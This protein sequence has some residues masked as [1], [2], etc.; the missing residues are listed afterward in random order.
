MFVSDWMTTKVFSVSANDNVA[1][2]IRTMKEKKIKHPFSFRRR[3][4]GMR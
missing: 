1:E 2:A 3:G 4:L